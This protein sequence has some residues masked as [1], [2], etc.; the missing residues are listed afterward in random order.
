M[1]A[2]GRLD[3]PSK[4]DSD[5]LS[6][7]SKNTI[8]N[9]IQNVINSSNDKNNKFEVIHEIENSDDSMNLEYDDNARTPIFGKEPRKPSVFDRLFDAEDQEGASNSN[10]FD[11]ITDLTSFK[12]RRKKE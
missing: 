6:V 4:L 9:L 12:P 10:L 5:H 2:S 1:D 11:S 3:V 7:N 8:N